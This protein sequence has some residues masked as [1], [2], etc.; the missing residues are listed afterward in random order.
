MLIS[1]IITTYNRPDALHLVLKSLET[2]SMEPLEVIIADDGSDERT[3]DL[4]TNYKKQSNLKIL[5]SFQVDK[6]FRASKSRNKAI[7]Q[8]SGDYI[9]LVDGDMVLHHHF[10]RDHFNNSELGCF[11]QGSRVLL[12]KSKTSKVIKQQILNCL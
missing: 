6:G 3:L 8:A 7:A 11:V 9:V 10:I 4:I 5:H 2:Q 12:S 1:L